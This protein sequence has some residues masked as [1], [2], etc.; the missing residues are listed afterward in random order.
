MKLI[1]CSSVMGE[2]VQTMSIEYN[3]IK[4][5]VWKVILEQMKNNG[6]II[7]NLG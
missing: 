1:F 7:G 2:R 4:Y 6:N 5:L 3:R